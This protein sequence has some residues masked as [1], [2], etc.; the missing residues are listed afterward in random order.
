R[1]SWRCERPARSRPSATRSP[2]ASHPRGHNHG[3]QW[4]VGQGAGKAPHRGARGGSQG[5]QTGGGG[6]GRGGSC[7]PELVHF[8]HRKLEPRGGG[9]VLP[10]VSR[11][12]LSAKR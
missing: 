2:R 12:L 9:S 6:R 1:K 10:H 7:L 3:R 4:Q 8:L 11:A 5:G